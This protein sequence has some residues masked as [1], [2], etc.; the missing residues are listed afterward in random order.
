MTKQ[1]QYIL[2]RTIQFPNM[3]VRVHRPVLAKEERA[4]RIKAITTAAAKLLKE[5]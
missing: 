3:A 2:E 1:D 5:R 4:A